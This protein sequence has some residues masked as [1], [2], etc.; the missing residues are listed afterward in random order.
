MAV[1]SYLISGLGN[2]RILDLDKSLRCESQSKIL[3][4]NMRRGRIMNYLPKDSFYILENFSE[5]SPPYLSLIFEFYYKE[6][7]PICS[8]V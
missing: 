4:I 8:R 2:H 1:C 5:H 7:K 6:A 3:D